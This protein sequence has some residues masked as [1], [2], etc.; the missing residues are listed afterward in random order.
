M[1][2]L[3][4]D[5]V[6]LQIA[7]VR[8]SDSIRCCECQ[9][10]G[11]SLWSCCAD[12][13]DLSPAAVRDFER[14]RDH[15]V[16]DRHAFTPEQ[17]AQTRRSQLGPAS[18]IRV[19]RR[20]GSGIP[21]SP[22]GADVGQSLLKLRLALHRHP[23]GDLADDSST[24]TQKHGLHWVRDRREHRAARAGHS[25]RIDPPVRGVHAALHLVNPSSTEMKPTDAR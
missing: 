8:S 17:A 5:R 4:L 7:P 20:S 18:R 14:W 23:N 19:R 24:S 13:V 2:E 25:I 9:A 10:D 1:D 11:G 16:K 6:D 3:S 21:C 15:V 12:G 22:R